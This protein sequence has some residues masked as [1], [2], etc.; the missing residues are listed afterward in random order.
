MELWIRSQ[1]RETLIRIENVSITNDSM[2]LGNLVSDDNKS[3]CD[4]WILGQYKTKRRALEIIDEIE[5]QIA[6]NYVMQTYANQIDTKGREDEIVK[7][8][9]KMIYEMP[10]E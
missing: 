5:N 7:L 6:S 10:K 1:D 2:V 8:F 4:Y 3:A 9:E